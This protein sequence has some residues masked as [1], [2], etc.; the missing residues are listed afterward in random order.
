MN[1]ILHITHLLTAYFYSPYIERTVPMKETPYVMLRSSKI[2]KHK[3]GSNFV[4][5]D[6]NRAS[7][8]SLKSATNSGVPYAD[9][10]D[11]S[12]ITTPESLIANTN[13]V[14]NT[15]IDNGNL[16]LSKQQTFFNSYDYKKQSYSQQI[17]NEFNETNLFRFKGPSLN[18]SSSPISSAPTQQSPH[19][20]NDH[21]E[22]F[23]IDL[24][25]LI[26]EMVGFD[27]SIELVPDGKYGVYDLETGEWNG[28]V[29]ELM[30]K[31]TK[32]M[33]IFRI[34]TNV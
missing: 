6:I 18:D 11:R 23:C 2:T 7:S 17:A 15:S 28:L 34:D 19:N 24:L 9:E 8:S 29:R 31:V 12:Q 22:G 21:F 26:A 33:Y 20:E 5:E 1:Y 25:R 13:L 16:L 27:Y 32:L 3:S 14:N 4:P 10:N 30:D